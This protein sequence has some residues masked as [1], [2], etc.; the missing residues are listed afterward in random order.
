MHGSFIDTKEVVCEEGK[1]THELFPVFRIRGSALT[2]VSFDQASK[3]DVEDL[4]GY[5]FG[6]PGMDLDYVRPPFTVVPE[7]GQ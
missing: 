2:V 6:A 1:G 7:N 5:V 4:V 3:Q